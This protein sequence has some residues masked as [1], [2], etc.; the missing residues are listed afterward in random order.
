MIS[1]KIKMKLDQSSVVH[2]TDGFRCTPEGCHFLA[3]F[4]FQFQFQFKR[5]SEMTVRQRDWTI[6]QNPGESGHFHFRSKE[7]ARSVA[8]QLNGHFITSFIPISA[9]RL[10]RETADSQCRQI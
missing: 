6:T 8:T 3:Q 7:A 4:R 1:E 9:A 2:D 5:L 10:A